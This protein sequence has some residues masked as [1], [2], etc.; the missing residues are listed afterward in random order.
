MKLERFL[1]NTVLHFIQPSDV[2]HT[3]FQ[4]SFLY[5]DPGGEVGRLVFCYFEGN[6]NKKTHMIPKT[7][8]L[9]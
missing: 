3:V 8:M 6:L 1:C 2:T 5:V 7:M 9:A 4:K